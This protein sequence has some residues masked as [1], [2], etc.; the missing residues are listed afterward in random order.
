LLEQPFILGAVSTTDTVVSKRRSDVI[1]TKHHTIHSRSH[2]G[3]GL[4]VP[5][6]DH[7]GHK[8]DLAQDPLGGTNIVCHTIIL[9]V[10]GGKVLDS[11][12][13][14]ALLRALNVGRRKDTRE[15]RI[16]REGFE[17]TTTERVLM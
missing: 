12:T 4:G 14:T 6:G 5:L 9:L 3:P 2:V 10:V 7:E 11:Y 15:D 1:S 17:R 13:N 16:L 8:V